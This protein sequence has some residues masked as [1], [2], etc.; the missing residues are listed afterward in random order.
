M[1]ITISPAKNQNFTPQHTTHSYTLPQHLDASATLIELLRQHSVEELS[2]LLGINSKLATLNVQRHFEWHLP[3][4]PNNGKQAAL[5]YDG[6]VYRGLNAQSLS[7]KEL[8]YAQQHL[9]IISGLYGALRP[10]DIIQ[11]YRLE[12]KTKLANPH[13]NDLY[14]FWGDR[15]TEEINQALTQS[16]KPNILLNLSSAEYFKSINKRL[17]NASQVIDFKF[18]QYYA[19]TDKTKTIVVYLKKAR[20]MMVRYII[21]N[22]INTLDGVKAFDMDGYWFDEKLSTD[23]CYVFVRQML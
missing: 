7:A 4:T 15:I 5:A 6:E 11:P 16:G 12:I 13:G 20:G 9:R 2:T 18:M 10:L 1:L 23:K 19:D 17:L 3:F 8:D 14:Q 21:Q 22:Q